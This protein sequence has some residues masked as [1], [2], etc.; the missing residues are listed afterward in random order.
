MTPPNYDAWSAKRL[1]AE[2]AAVKPELLVALAGLLASGEA[3]AAQIDAGLNE[4]IGFLMGGWTGQTADNAHRSS[5]ATA[6]ASDRHSRSAGSAKLRT[7]AFS[8]AL[9]TSKATVAAVP[10]D[11]PPQVA[12]YLPWA[13]LGP[14]G[15]SGASAAYLYNAAQAESQ[16]RALV[17][18]I[19]TI[20]ETGRT[21]GAG[22]GNSFA[23]VR[24]DPAPAPEPLPPGP[25]G[26]TGSGGSNPTRTAPAARGTG[27]STPGT[28]A[29]PRGTTGFAP[30]APVPS[31]S[32]QTVPGI[33]AA[34]GAGTLPQSFTV[35]T[36]TG[37]AGSPTAGL[38][39]T[40]AAVPGGAGLVGSAGG[41]GGAL[42]GGALATGGASAA[43]GSSSVGLPG[44]VSGGWKPGAAG[45]AP[46]GVTAEPTSGPGMS[47]QPG[48]MR[49]GS[50][51]TG[52]SP[53]RTVGRGGVVRSGVG[54]PGGSRPGVLSPG[55]GAGAGGRTGRTAL[56][57]NVGARTAAGGRRRHGKDNE[58]DGRPDYLVESDDVWGDGR[59]VVR[60]V[61]GQKPENDEGTDW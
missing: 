31:A 56:G 39:P 37:A 38:L 14:V 35:P 53:R 58:L 44:T 1:K 49:G 18:M 43:L 9:T 55:Q 61:L 19:K 36:A 50:G 47:G 7:V 12:D 4:A 5:T 21:A 25:G 23:A 15:A 22:V 57:R 40:G 10:A 3:A 60:G 52:Q 45:S 34:A 17:A 27:S 32:G 28:P 33:P 51:S 6:Q 26:G 46:G 59:T 2:A 20:D 41:A 13:L 16:R 54:E 24:I 48:A 11:D 8:A 30:G 42:L 29:T